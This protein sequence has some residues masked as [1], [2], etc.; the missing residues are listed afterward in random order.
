MG[1]AQA[2]IK[3]DFRSGQRFYYVSIATL[4]KIIDVNFDYTMTFI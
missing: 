4:H 2:L 1:E 3:L